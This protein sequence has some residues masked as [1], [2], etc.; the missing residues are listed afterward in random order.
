MQPGP[1]NAKTFHIAR[2]QHHYKAH[3]CRGHH[4]KEEDL[5]TRIMRTQYFDHGI[6]AGEAEVCEQTKNDSLY[7]TGKPWLK[8]QRH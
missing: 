3:Q 6:T 5:Q 1:V 4:V 7:F 8:A 2:Q